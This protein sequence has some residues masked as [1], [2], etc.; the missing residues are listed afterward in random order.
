M[1]NVTILMFPES[2]GIM[3]FIMSSGRCCCYH[4]KI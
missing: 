1:A 2:I 4:A 3:Y